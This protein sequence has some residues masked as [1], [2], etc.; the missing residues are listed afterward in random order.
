[1]TN[2]TI[3]RLIDALNAHKMRDRIFRA[4]LS[5]A[6]EYAKVWLHEP[7]GVAED[8]RSYEF[9]FIKNVTGI[10]VAAVFDAYN[11]LHVFVK[12]EY[13]KKGHLARAMN[14]VIFPYLY[15]SGRGMQEV[16]FKDPCVGSYCAKNWGF[17]IISDSFAKK[18]LSFFADLPAIELKG[19]E[20]TLEDFEQIEV[21]INKARL[22]LT[23][24]REQLTI[25]YGQPSNGN[26]EELISDLSFIK[27]DIRDFCLP[28]IAPHSVK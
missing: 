16:T 25:A 19:Q 6:V 26:L 2:E 21:K 7:K 14:E 23:M 10:Y 22:Y 27:D 15:Q 3:E 12:E 4:S 11:D 8:E 28:A 13:R 5:P 18:D 20:C 17:T 1:M 9:F 24:V